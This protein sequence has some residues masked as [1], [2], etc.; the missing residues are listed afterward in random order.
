MAAAGTGAEKVNVIT[1]LRG[2]FSL[3]WSDLRYL[4]LTNYNISFICIY[5]FLG[6]QNCTTAA[7]NRTST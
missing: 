7:P 3:P 2:G 5:R 4:P 6:H 1:C